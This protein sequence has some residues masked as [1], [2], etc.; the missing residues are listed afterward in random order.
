MGRI[1][2]VGERL[3]TGQT[4]PA[5]HHPWAALHELEEVAPGV[6]FVSSFANSTALETPAGLVV[7][8][9]GA[10]PFGSLVHQAVRGWSALPVHTIVYT[11]GH[12][13]HVFGTVHF[14]REARSAART[15]P[16]VVAHEAVPARFD[17]YRR[18]AGYN[19]VI[20]ARQFRLP[21]FEWPTDYR[22][23]DRTYRDRLALEVGGEEII[24]THG[25]GE[26]DDHTWLWLPAR[27]L[28]L[29][30]DLF[31]WATP[32]C[33]NPQKVQ[34]YPREWAEALRRMVALEPEIL[35]PGHGYP[36]HGAARVRQALTETAEL[37]ESLYEQTL[38]L[39][40]AGA[41]LDDILHTV[42]APAHLLAR[43]YL[44]PIYDEPQFIVRNLWRL[45]GGW[46]DGNP[47]HLKP[48][49]DA[50]VAREVAALA[51]GATRLADRATALAGTGELALA[52]HLAELAA[53][54]APGDA[55][56]R[57]AR[58]AV[59]RARA[60]AERSVM[61]RGVYAW[62]AEEG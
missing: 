20:N 4:T 6:G 36:I 53:Q 60:A 28:L 25:L 5:D 35:L 54:A 50:A 47:A 31:I 13:D 44:Q 3:W 30:G 34:R 55:G 23:P 21:D 10:V 9:T 16:E 45:Y 41:R 48:A 37:L 14:E 61:A 2:D 29:T 7:V 52:C 24:L 33:G 8:D 15:A 58:A 11:H 27:K 51:G 38:A 18:T 39:M 62:A 32:N 19:R 22:Y 12:V 57:A 43:P 17:R 56:I 46:Y 40:N 42:Q 59:Y 49:A 1:S 26:T